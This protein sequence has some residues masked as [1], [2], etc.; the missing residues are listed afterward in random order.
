[1]WPVDAI[2]W[3]HD[4]PVTISANGQRYRA[5][6]VRLMQFTGLRDLNGKEIYEGD[7]LR[8]D[9]GFKVDDRNS[10]V[11]YENGSFV[12]NPEVRDVAII[13]ICYTTRGPLSLEEFE[14]IG[15]IYEDE[16]LLATR[17]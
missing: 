4:Q 8:P 2:E 16:F 5:D 7:V 12:A 3:H 6:T 1:M 15:N 17:V 13:D 14:V 10:V 9:G 11:V